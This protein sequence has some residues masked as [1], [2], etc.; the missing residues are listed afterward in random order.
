ME[1]RRNLRAKRCALNAIAGLCSLTYL[2]PPIANYLSPYIL[3]SVLLVEGLAFLWLL[4]MGVN[5][6]RWKEQAGASVK[7]LSIVAAVR[8]QGG[9][10]AI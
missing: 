3:A 6:Q 5:D 8:L 9:N 4:V 10:E 7:P 1:L 2:S